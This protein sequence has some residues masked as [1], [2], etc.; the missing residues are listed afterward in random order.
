MMKAITLHLCIFLLICRNSFGFQIVGGSR[1]K[2]AATS[3]SLDMG[4]FDFKTFHGS[5]SASNNDLDEQW[6]IQQEKLAERRGHLDKAHL[7]EK[8]KGGEGKFEIHAKSTLQSHM[9]DMY[10]DQDTPRQHKENQKQGFKL[11]FPWE[12]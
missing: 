12:K 11:K 2:K 4:L 10:I 3:T 9:D 1:T 6:R 7:K 5:G 8:Y